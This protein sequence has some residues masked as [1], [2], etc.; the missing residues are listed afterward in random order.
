M[1]SAPT[2]QGFITPTLGHNDDQVSKDTRCR[3]CKSHVLG[4]SNRT[5]DYP[6][7]VDWPQRNAFAK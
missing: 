2:A 3:E 1:C 4:G 6:T 5:G 7:L